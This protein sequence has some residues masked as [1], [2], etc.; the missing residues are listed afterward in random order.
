MKQEEILEY[1]KRC[2]EFLGYTF[3]HYTNDKSKATPEIKFVWGA[4]AEILKRCNAWWRCSKTPDDNFS[5]NFPSDL[6][7]HSNWNWIHEV[8]E[9]IENKGYDVF[10][11]GLYCRITDSGMTDFE[12]E[13]GAATTKQEAVVQAIN[14]FLI[15]YNE[16]N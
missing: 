10:I 9:A 3:S 13:S 7:F 15:W 12:I 6:L 11:N 2:A 4:E 1:N 5:W 16:N 8:V 14:Q